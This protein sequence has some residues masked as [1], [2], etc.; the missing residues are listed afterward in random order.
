MTYYLSNLLSKRWRHVHVRCMMKWRIVTYFN[1]HHCGGF[2]FCVLDHSLSLH[3]KCYISTLSKCLQAAVT[4]KEHCV[5]QW[6]CTSYS[7]SHSLRR[8]PRSIRRSTMYL[9]THHKL[10]S[11]SWVK[12]IFRKKC[13]FRNSQ[14]NEWLIIVRLP[15]LLHPKY[16]SKRDPEQEFYMN[17]IRPKDYSTV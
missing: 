2:L 10:D 6:S 1:I 16:L 15:I 5:P 4:D 17:K 13:A 9:C 8:R 12:I 11:Y 7:I 3:F 14:M